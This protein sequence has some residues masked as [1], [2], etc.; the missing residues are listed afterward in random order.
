MN[1]KSIKPIAVLVSICIVVA[2]LLGAVNL[3]TKDVIAENAIRKEQESL[4]KVL[5]GGD[6]FEEVSIGEEDGLP[7]TVKTVYRE[8]K[9]IGYVV[10]L[11]TRTEYSSGD[12]AISVGISI[13]GKVEGALVTN[14]QES[15]DMGKTTYPEKFVGTS[16][17]DY[18][19]VD[20][21]SGVTYSSSAFK[22]AIGD[23]LKAVEL[24]FADGSASI[25]R[26]PALLLSTSSEGAV[27]AGSSDINDIFP[28]NSFTKKELNSSAPEHL[29]ALYSNSADE[30]LIA[31]LVVPGEWVPIATEAFV[32]FD[33]YGKIADMKLT[34]WV[35]GHGVNPDSSFAEGFIG[36]Y[37]STVGFT[38]LVSGATGT[39]RDL[40]NA[41]SEVAAFLTQSVDK[42]N[43]KYHFPEENWTPVELTADAPEYLA[44]L[45]KSTTSNNTVAHVIVPGEW[46]PVAS[47]AFILYNEL[48]RIVDFRLTK[49]IVGHGVEPDEDFIDGFCGKYEGD[50]DY[51]DLVSGAT[52]TSVDLRNAVSDISDF[53]V[54]DVDT[55]NP[56]HH[57][58]EEDWT[59]VE[60]GADAPEYLA[61]LYKS[62]TSDRT[63][64]HVIVPGEWV[65]VATEAFVLYNRWGTIVD[66]KL[67]QWV[68]G[69][70]VN[71]SSSFI[72]GFIGK[73]IEAVKETELVT[74]A[75]GTSVDLRSAVSEVSEYLSPNKTS[76]TVLGIILISLT[77]L[78]IVAVT[79][80]PRA[81]IYKKAR[82]SK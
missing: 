52:G 24:L 79:V 33:K 53:I 44:A 77:V 12:M 28:N 51:V 67:T 43:P 65:P 54:K 64:A 71:P 60:L 26:S 14:Y 41:V 57:F 15:K 78:S 42:A 45:Y 11:N 7:G 70:G 58:P 62:M 59:P 72:D 5:S 23:A 73:S 76:H 19:N 40:R 74:G 56:K 3:L 21:V 68:V 31:H 32:T 55:S 69:H 20:T 38:D 4:R 48:G 75:T 8:T 17:K 50:V 25:E 18:Q 63:V 82:N 30:T 6:I 35:V 29:V 81:I 46:V 22:A 36:K 80:I 47:E 37:D 13:D 10:L 39:S 34:Q 16:L 9:G 66:F 27:P 49:W 1:L 61:A 2:A